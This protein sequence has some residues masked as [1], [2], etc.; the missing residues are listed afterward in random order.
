[1]DRDELF[2]KYDKLVWYNVNKKTSNPL[3]KKVEDDMYAFVWQWILK[4]IDKFDKTKSSLNTFIMNHI[5][6]ALQTFTTDFY[7]KGKLYKKY[8]SEELMDEKKMDWLESD[9]I[10]ESLTKEDLYTLFKKEHVD[11]AIQLIKE[12]EKKKDR[13]KYQRLQYLIRKM[14]EE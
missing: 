4:Y 6:W 3:F 7:E 1:M 5:N 13:K 8:A 11:E 9:E 14:K 10:E 2:E 12:L